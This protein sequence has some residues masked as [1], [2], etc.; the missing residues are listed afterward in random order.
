MP[1]IW[2][3][4]IDAICQHLQ[5]I[6]EGRLKKLVINIGPGHAKS[7]ISSVLWPAWEWL[8]KPGIRYLCGSYALEL[9]LRDNLRSRDLIQSDWYR[10]TFS[11]SWTLKGDQNVK[12]YYRNSAKGERLAIS[13]GK[14]ATGF[15]GN[16]IILDDPLSQLDADNAVAKEEF[17]RWYRSTLTTRVNDPRDVVVICIMQRLAEDDPTAFLLEMGGFDH[18]CLPERYISESHCST[19]IG[20]SDPRTEDGELLFPELF[21]EEVVQQ[22]QRQLG[23][24]VFS[25]Q[26]LQSPVPPGGKI[27]KNHWWRW[28]DQ[29]PGDFDYILQ[30]WD[31]AFKELE[32]SSYVVGQVWGV[33]G[34]DV[35]LLDQVRAHLAFPETCDAVVALSEKWPS[36]SLILIEDK[37]NGPAI[38][39]SLRH[40]LAGIVPVT[41]FGSKA[42]RA[43]AVTPFCESGNVWLPNQH[44]CD[45]IM[46]FVARVGS[47]PKI[48][49]DDEVDAMSQ[50]LSRIFLE[51]PP[52][53]SRT[54]TGYTK[55]TGTG[56]TPR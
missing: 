45:W 39:A 9:A 22:L 51:K 50:A 28:Y 17:R 55:R 32:S 7:L 37:A 26:S 15:R 35:Y 42:S 48:A 30:S 56:Y 5:A 40:K 19:S 31:M 11:P 43:K 3:W 25:A 8:R 21:T 16:R 6:T 44:I 1:L 47:F 27:F 24:D 52:G 54:S 18:L 12:G 14:S 20:W 13:P 46:D 2:G 10:K 38:I 23:S 49:H 29:V 41:P 33:K 34:A 4:H 53:S 36:T